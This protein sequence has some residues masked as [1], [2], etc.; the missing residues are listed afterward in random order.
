MSENVKNYR[1]CAIKF[2]R[3][4][5]VNGSCESASDPFF[6]TGK[7]SKKINVQKM[8]GSKYE[9]RLC[10]GQNR[11]IAAGS[12]NIHGSICQKDFNYL[13]MQRKISIAIQGVL[14]LVL[15]GCFLLLFHN[16]EWINQNGQ[17]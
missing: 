1:S 6:L 14:E 11:T 16:M 5:E 4:L 7:T 2:M 12:F 9:L 8:M 15:K 3:L 13:R 17:K 10:L